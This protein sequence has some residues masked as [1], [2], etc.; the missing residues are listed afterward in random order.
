MFVRRAILFLQDAK[1]KM[2]KTCCT[3]VFTERESSEQR[4]AWK[5][6]EMNHGD[7]MG[8]STEA[9]EVREA[10]LSTARSQH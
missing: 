8:R 7:T 3:L 2:A 4:D 1:S 10:I 5:D 9:T 6:G